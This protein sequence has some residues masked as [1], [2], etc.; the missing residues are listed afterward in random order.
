M[1][2]TRVCGKDLALINRA[3][4]SEPA[5]VRRTER[6]SLMASMASVD[7]AGDDTDENASTGSRRGSEM[8]VDAEDD[9]S[10]DD[11]EL[12][13]RSSSSTSR[14]VAVAALGSKR[15]RTR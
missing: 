2:L 1:V 12:S 9:D 7:S 6:A 14:S 3:V 15:R 4:N 5:G 11:D 10:D 8:D 13:E